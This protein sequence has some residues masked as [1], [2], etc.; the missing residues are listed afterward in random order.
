MCY[1]SHVCDANRSEILT[2]VLRIEPAHTII[3]LPQ[4][5]S[6]VDVNLAR[7]LRIRL[8]EL[9]ANLECLDA[10]L[11]DASLA[12]KIRGAVEAER[13]SEVQLS[14]VQ[15]ITIGIVGQ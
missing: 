8:A 3:R 4:L 1:I 15:K 13:A 7:L 2:K 12:R 6:F 10:S 9:L 5:T 14:L 11:E